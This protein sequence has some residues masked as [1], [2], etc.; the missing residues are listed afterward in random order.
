MEGDE[1]GVRS[2]LD[3]GTRPEVT[4]PTD[5]GESWS[6]LTVAA[7]KGHEHLLSL[8]LQA[9]LSIEGGGTTD[10]TP[11][12]MAAQN[13]HAHTVKAL[14][15]LRAVCG[16]PLAR[17]PSHSRTP[18]GIHPG[19]TS[20]VIVATWRYWSSWQVLAGPSPPGTVMATHPCTLLRPGVEV[21]C[22]QWLVQRGGDT[23]MQNNAGHTSLD[24][25]CVAAL[26]PVTSPTPAHPE[27]HTPV[28]LA[29]YYGH[30]EVLEQLAGAGWP[31]TA[32]DSDG[33]TPM[34][35]AAAGGRVTCVQWL[36]Q[37]GGDTS[38]QNNAGHTPL[39]EVGSAE[40]QEG[41]RMQTVLRSGSKF[42][43]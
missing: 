40:G 19:A 13:G 38:M 26:L 36:V 17:H 7:F 5:A 2:A 34:H 14:L 9:G 8:L 30:V 42:N 24:K 29:S 43:R 11:L 22:V 23:S 25:Q 1:A 6:L 32:R 28:H 3:R 12:M 27:A 16:G 20:P 35:S 41:G 15:D 10:I 21:T 39:D 4:V 37:R 18:R 31:L 33:N